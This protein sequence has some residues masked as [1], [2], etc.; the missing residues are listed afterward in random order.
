[1]AALTRALAR[2]RA[3]LGAFAFC[4]L[5]AAA[6]GPSSPPS[7]SGSA[8]SSIAPTGFR[9][10]TVAGP[11]CPV[12]R[13]NDPACADRPVAGA[14]I[15]VLDANG[16]EIARLVSDASG[17]FGLPVPAGTYRLVADPIEGA[18]RAPAPAEVVVDKGI[19][20]IDLAYDTGIR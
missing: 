18:L 9:G 8:D 14:T 20:E 4:V 6:C 2:F 13:P 19:A 7:G 17:G 10:H 1:V 15:H 5:V 11:T 12:V 3:L 16:T